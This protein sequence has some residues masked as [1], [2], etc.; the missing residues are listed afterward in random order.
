MSRFIFDTGMIVG[1]VRDAGFTQYLDKKYQPLDPPNVSLISAVS[2]GEI[3][4]LAIQF[5]WGA[6]KKQK[7]QEILA[8]LPTVDI[9]RTPI[10]ERYAEIDA[11][12]QGKDPARPL[13]VGLSARNMGKNDVW[14]AATA[15]VLGAK[16]V[17]IDRDFDH[18]NGIFLDVVYVDQSLTSADA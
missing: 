4:S 7:L 16:L 3:L 1:Y 13:P 5:G 11:Y 6:A 18:L 2:K 10:L 8:K 9:R 15:S 17:T 14:I 12:S